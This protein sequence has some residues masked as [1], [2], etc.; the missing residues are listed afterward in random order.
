MSANVI[1]SAYIARQREF[2][3]RTFGP[4]L[5]TDGVLD[6]IAKEFE[7]VREAPRD[8]TEWADIIILALDG[9][10]RTGAEPQAIIDAVIAKQTKNEAR[11]W[12]DWRTQPA[13]QA[14][15]HVRGDDEI[16]RTESDVTHLVTLQMAWGGLFDSHPSDGY[17]A[18]LV[19]GTSRGMPG[20]TL[21]GI[22]RFAKD[23][24][25]WSVGGGVS[26][27]G[28]TNEPCAGCVTVAAKDFRGLPITGLASDAVA[29][30]VADV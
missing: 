6:H 20:P 13:G 15:E 11:N 9:A 8:V 23:A 17:E 24:P 30:A 12:P 21:C 10:Q 7:E 29:K 2:S 16:G 5:R 25:G 1:D 27:P 22:D 28:I 4:G 14:I 26:G 18:H 19:R 3:L